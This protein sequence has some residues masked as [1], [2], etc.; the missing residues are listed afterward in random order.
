MN[1]FIIVFREVL[2]AALIVGII[3]TILIKNQLTHVIK[4]VWLGVGTSVFASVLIGLLVIQLKQW[5][6]NN[7]YQALFE[8]IFLYITAGFLYYVIF[9]LSKHVSDTKKLETDTLKSVQLSSW[10]IFFLVFFAILREGFETVIFL[11]SSFTMQGTFSYTGFI[12]GAMLAI[13]IGVIVVIQ[14]KKVR[15]TKFFQV[16]SLCL[17][18]IAS[19]MVA[20]GTHEMEEYFVKTNKIQNEHIQRPWTI[21]EPKMTLTHSDFSFLYTYNEP[22]QKYIHILHDK[23][24]V[25]VFLKG[26]LGYNSNPNYIE[27]LLWITSLVF[28]INFW[29][30]FYQTV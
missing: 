24:H 21:L 19:G 22:K 13:F 6:G 28:G 8:G 7:A 25:G 23:G 16:T 2:E 12:L 4:K 27:L 18:F 1:E 14:G 26:F 17:V 15:I 5:V 11:V 3:Y 10:G 20:Y 29:R 30:R 9:W